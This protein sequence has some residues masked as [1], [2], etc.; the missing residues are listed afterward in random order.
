M[1]LGGREHRRFEH[2]N[3]VA[4]IE[5][6]GREDLDNLIEQQD[7]RRARVR[8]GGND[9]LERRC[10]GRLFNGSEAASADFSY[11]CLIGSGHAG[12]ARNGGERALH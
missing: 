8:V 7:S 12:S 1:W 2:P 4:C 11:R 6:R 9:P 5:V 10:N 3:K